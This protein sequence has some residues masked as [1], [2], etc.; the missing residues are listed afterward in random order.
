MDLLLNVII[1]TKPSVSISELDKYEQLN[2]KLTGD[3]ISTINKNN[4]RPSIGFKK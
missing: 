4:E 3:H 1:N 2:K